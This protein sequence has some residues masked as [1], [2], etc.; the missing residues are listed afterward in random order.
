MLI[1]ETKISVGRGNFDG[2]KFLDVKQNER[3]I[4]ISVTP[5]RIDLIG[6]LVSATGLTR[7]DVAE[8]LQR[9][10]PKYFAGVEVNPEKFLLDAARIINA[11]KNKQIIENLKYTV[12]DEHY[13]VRIFFLTEKGRLNV[14][15]ISTRKN[16]YS[17][18]IFADSNVEKNFAE[19]LEADEKVE[20][21][22]K[23]P[24]KF[25]IPTPFGNYNPD[26]A[27]VLR[28][29]EKIYFV[30]ETKGTSDELQLRDIEKN[31]IECAKKHFAALGN[32]VDYEMVGSFDEFL[33]K[34]SRHF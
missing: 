21:Y 16:I 14:N 2:E 13:D 5:A 22:A 10:E 17:H 31:K 33:N 8:I 11:V 23:L 1:P 30:V 18:L 32:A 24:P 20:V 28:G 15:A 3:L 4:E 12:T 9:V 25:F 6:K 29:G 7:R 19:N 34:I 27:I 26:W